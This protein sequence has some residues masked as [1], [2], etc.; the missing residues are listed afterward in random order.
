MDK[1]EFEILLDKYIRKKCSDQEI[2]LME[3]FFESYK[4]ADHLQEFDKE[5]LDRF[6]VQMQQQIKSKVLS[7]EKKVK[8]TFQLRSV[9]IFTFVILVAGLISYQKWASY[10]EFQWETRSV[11]N[12][13]KATVMLGDGTL[14]F[15]NSGSTIQFPKKFDQ[16][17]RVI[18][19]TG[20]AYFEVARDVERPFKIATGEL[21]TT[22]L[23]TSFNIRAYETEEVA[24]TV[25]TGKVKVGSRENEVVLTPGQQAL[26]GD[27]TQDIVKHAVD[28]EQFLAWKDNTI[29]LDNVTLEKAIATLERWYNVEIRFKNPQLRFCRISG[30]FKNE[31]LVTILKSIRFVKDIDY[32]FE[33]NNQIILYGQTCEI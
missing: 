4:D 11:S 1:P 9:H 15:L 25:L 31:S 24:V 17:E 21:T 32:K 7:S 22:V 19:L 16:D 27:P 3:D 20:E 8:K 33:D 10:D 14:V 23:G 18:N 12:G 2:K 30:K 5:T 6:K 28:T 26:Y 29:R 13:Q